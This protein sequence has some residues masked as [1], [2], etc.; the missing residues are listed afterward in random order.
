M[1]DPFD[2][3]L[4]S[5]TIANGVLYVGS[6]DGYVYALSAQSGELRWK[7][8]TGDVVHASPAV[9]NGLVYV[10][11]WGGFFYALDATTGQLRWRFKTGEDTTI[12]N[13]VGIQSSATVFAGEVCLFRMS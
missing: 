5:P 10:G 2:V 7:Y 12:F 11:S 6:G 9:A 1:P 4:S 3:F 13:Q 8:R